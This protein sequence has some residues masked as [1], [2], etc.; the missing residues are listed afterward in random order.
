M[1]APAARRLFLG[2]AALTAVA[3]VLPL[4]GFR[5]SAP[6]YPGESLSLRVTTRA[7]TGDV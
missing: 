3:L 1:N 4:W 7:I 5:M 2:A 6:Q